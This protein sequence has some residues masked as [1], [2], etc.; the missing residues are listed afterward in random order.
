MGVRNVMTMTNGNATTVTNRA[1]ELLKTGAHTGDLIRELGQVSD[2]LQV[3]HPV[4]GVQSWLVPVVVDELIAGFFRADPS[5]TDWQWTSFQRRQDSLAGCPQ[6]ATWLDLA[7]IKRRAEALAEVG[8]IVRDAVLS[9]DGVPDRVAWA[10]RL[11]SADSSE[12]VIF[13]AGSA[14][15]PATIGPVDSYRG[16]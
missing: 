3:T 1:R 15:W 10:V 5:L 11:V 4:G 2:A 6:A 12:R 16:G 7:V 8:E 14:A 9:F 13:V